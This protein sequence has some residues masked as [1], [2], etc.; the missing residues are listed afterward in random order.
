VAVYIYI[1]GIGLSKAPRDYAR[2]VGPSY[3]GWCRTGLIKTCQNNRT[4]NN[5]SLSGDDLSDGRK[6]SHIPRTKRNSKTKR[7]DNQVDIFA[8][9]I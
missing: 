4:L 9:I 1:A 8:G 3:S 6:R 5:N 7:S 2:L